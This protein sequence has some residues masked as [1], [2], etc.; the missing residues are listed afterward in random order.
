MDQARRELPG[1][2]LFAELPPDVAWWG[3]AGAAPGT[4]IRCA[5]PRFRYM[6]A[7]EPW[8]KASSSIS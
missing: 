1:L 6:R 5:H 2:Y 7:N 4:L 8:R 3:T